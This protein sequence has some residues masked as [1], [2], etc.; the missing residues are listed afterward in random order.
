MVNNALRNQINPHSKSPLY[1]QIY[2]LL[3]HKILGG[4]WHPNDILPSEAELMA[5][6]KVS[7]ATIRQALDELATDGLIYRKQGKGTFVSPPTV[8][9]GLVRIVSFTED[10]QQRGFMPGTKLISAELVPATEVLASQLQIEV[11]EP[12]ARIE[13]LRLADDEPMSVEV[14]FLVHRYCPGILA[15]DYTA[16]SLRQMLE[17]NYGI[18]ITSAQ[19]TIQAVSATKA[20]AELLTIENSAALLYIERLSFSEFGAPVEYLRLYHRGDRYTL[21]ADLRG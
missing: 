18:R 12:L 7:R 11:G 10:M 1:Q 13:R 20:L 6:Y 21:H 16:H 5:Q 8:E 19:Q 15:Q 17:E 14:S 3:R 2:E 4:S 9:Q